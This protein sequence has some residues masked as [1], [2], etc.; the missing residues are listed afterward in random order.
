M[1]PSTRVLLVADFGRTGGTR[2]FLDELL[3]TYSSV[4]WSVDLVPVA[5]AVDGRL[6][7]TCDRLGVTLIRGPGV[8]R[9]LLRANRSGPSSTGW[10][11]NTRS[12]RAEFRELQISRASTH[13]VVST[14]TPGAHVAA[15]SD[16]IKSLY[17]LHTYPHG[18]RQRILGNISIGRTLPSKTVV[19]AVSSYQETQMAK[20]WFR[21]SPRRVTVIRNAPTPRPSL[22]SG[23]SR[24][25]SLLTVGALEPYKQPNVWLEAAKTWRRSRAQSSH[26]PLE[27]MSWVWVGSGSLEARVLNQLRTNPWLDHVSMEGEVIDPTP[28]FG[29]A[30]MYV[31]PSSLENMSF[32]VLEA[33]SHGL[34]CIVTNAGA[35]PEIIQDGD[36]GVIVP[37]NDPA[38]LAGAVSRVLREPQWSQH[39]GKRAQQVIAERHDFF[40]WKARIIEAHGARME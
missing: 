40:E 37:A 26:D 30:R 33:M 4:G 6:R 39:L 3:A 12:L 38:A 5:S 13:V 15:L 36:S 11:P 1:V 19:L 32:S 8:N 34:P 22:D 7:E 23:Q 10:L 31:Q 29:R 17:I 20:H 21:Y 28:F 9:R 2:T 35:L 27:Q 18:F 14:G 25:T 24:K 16:E